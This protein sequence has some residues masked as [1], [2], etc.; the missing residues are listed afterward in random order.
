MLLNVCVFWIPYVK[1]TLLDCFYFHS[2]FLAFLLSA[3]SSRAQYTALSG[4]RTGHLASRL[5]DAYLG[6]GRWIVNQI[7]A[8]MILTEG[9]SGSALLQGRNVVGTASAAA[10]ERAY[11]VP[12]DTY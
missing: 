8:S 9:D 6:N 4:I 1:T 5:S 12:A 2:W 3:F 10:S 7:V 11:F